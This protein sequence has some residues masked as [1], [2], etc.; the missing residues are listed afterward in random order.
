VK[1]AAKRKGSLV[2]LVCLLGA[3][4][5]EGNKGGSEGDPDVE[6][7]CIA[8]GRRW[9]V[10]EQCERSPKQGDRFF[11]G[12][13]RRRSG[14][15]HAVGIDGRL[16]HAGLVVVCGELRAGRV[17]VVVALDRDRL[18]DG[19]VELTATSWT[20]H[21]QGNRPKL[22]VAEVVGEPLIADDPSTPELIDMVDELWLTDP[23]G[24]DQQT[25]E[26]G[27]P[28]TA[29]T[30]ASRRAPSGSWPSRAP[31]TARIVGVSI[32]RLP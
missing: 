15:R 29:A 17:D 1:L 13:H 6:F 10:G 20:E 3:V 19:S 18:G 32:A 7:E 22:V 31:S 16:D 12:R 2:E 27:R 24:R 30:S 8:V 21:L 11:E 26:K 9:Q 5:L 14:P 4:A 25:D 28:M 23:R